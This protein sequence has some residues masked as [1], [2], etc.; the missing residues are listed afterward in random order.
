M[1]LIN[2]FLD[3]LQW[4]DKAQTPLPN[5]SKTLC[6]QTFQVYSL[7]H[8]QF[9]K[10]NS[11]RDLVAVCRTDT[12]NLL[13]PTTTK[14]HLEL[15]LQFGRY[16]FSVCHQLSLYCF[17]SLEAYKT[18]RNP[19]QELITPKTQVQCRQVSHCSFTVLFPSRPLWPTPTSPKAV[20]CQVTLTTNIRVARMIRLKNIEK[21]NCW[22]ERRRGVRRSTALY[23]FTTTSGTILKS[24]PNNHDV[25]SSAEVN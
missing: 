23:F 21:Y 19:D 15:D 8:R 14:S 6:D 25:R 11:F 18:R 24:R 2:E 9:F 3:S 7:Q 17:C 13:I 22:V 5:I 10:S 12:M 4:D 1:K 16:F 20:R